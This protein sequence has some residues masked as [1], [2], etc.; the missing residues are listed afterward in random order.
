MEYTEYN[1]ILDKGM[2]DYLN[3]GGSVFY[4]DNIAKEYIFSYDDK[5]L[6]YESKKHL[7]DKTIQSILR[8]QPLPYGIYLEKCI[9]QKGR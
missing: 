3:G 4:M 7:E 6:S 8:K 2:V 5:L 9:W 1:N